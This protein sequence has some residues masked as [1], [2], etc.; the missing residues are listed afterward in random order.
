[1]GKPEY[2]ALV[3]NVAK[4]AATFHAESCYPYAMEFEAVAFAKEIVALFFD[5]LSKPTPEMLEAWE[6]TESVPGAREMTSAELN[7]ACATR[8]LVAMLKASH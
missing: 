4:L 3:E 2:V 5:R 6:T 7:I 1:M 8:D